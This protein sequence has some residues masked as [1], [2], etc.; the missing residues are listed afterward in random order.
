M[1]KHFVYDGLPFQTRLVATNDQTNL[2]GVGPDAIDLHSVVPILGPPVV[3]ADLLGYWNLS[4]TP[5]LVDRYQISAR[6]ILSELSPLAMNVA[7]AGTESPVVRFNTHKL[8]YNYILPPGL[9]DTIDLLPRPLTFDGPT[10]D[11]DRTNAITAGRLRFLVKFLEVDHA[12]IKKHDTEQEAWN[13]WGAYAI[14]QGSARDTQRARANYL[15][16]P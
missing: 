15:I 13:A 14:S 11:T 5:P 3:Q 4:P 16:K 8:G 1:A 6:E 10:V 12:N 9:S 7:E 2:M